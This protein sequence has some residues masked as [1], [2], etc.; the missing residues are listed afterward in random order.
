MPAPPCRRTL[1]GLGDLAIFTGMLLIMI[2][3]FALCG[4]NIFGQESIQF[5]D[6]VSPWVARMSR[7]GLRRVLASSD[8]SRALPP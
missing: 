1:L 7:S 4:M 2:V 6:P 3:G 8:I 5:V